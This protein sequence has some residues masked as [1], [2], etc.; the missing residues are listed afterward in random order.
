MS[1]A[2]KIKKHKNPEKA[3]GVVRRKAPGDLQEN[4]FRRVEEAD[5]DLKETAW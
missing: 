2:G 3:T 5:L 4:R 1:D